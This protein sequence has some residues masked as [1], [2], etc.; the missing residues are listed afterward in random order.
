MSALAPSG[1]AW[2]AVRTHRRTLWW[3][4]GLTVLAVALLVAVRLWSTHLADEFAGSGC[5]IRL[6]DGTC[7]DNTWFIASSEWTYSQLMAKGSA[8]IALLPFLVAA[9]VAGPVVGR[10]MESGTYRMLWTQSVSPVR[11][12]AVKL[13]VPAA[14]ALAGSTV[15]IGAYRWAWSTGPG[16]G[17]PGMEWYDIDVYTAIGPVGIAATVL[18]VPV[19]AL[20]GLLVR[21]TVSAMVSGMFTLG[22]LLYVPANFRGNFWTTRT[23]TGSLADGYPPYDGMV[24]GDGAL[25]S[26][27]AQV[28]DPMCVDDKACLTAHHIVGY[29]RTSQPASH[30]WQLQLVETGILLALAVIAAALVLRI[31]KRTTA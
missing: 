18:A 4:L 12:F 26:S 30:F 28:S 7:S 10:E 20:I 14:M 23:V 31:V 22:V 19:G 21:R 5:P 11:W 6:S 9:F 15:L 3:A 8:V 29:Y 17:G 24:L 13:A 27:G 1:P 16:H 25:T 2:V